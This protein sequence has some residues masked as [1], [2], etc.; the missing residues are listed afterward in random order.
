MRNPTK[1]LITLLCMLPLSS[2]L[3]AASPQVGVAMSAFDDNWLTILR[4]AIT[5][6]AKKEGATV[7]MEDGKNEVGTQLN[8]IQNFA[9]SSLQAI[10]VNPVDSTA[11]QSISDE[12]HEAEIPLVYVN[13]EP[14]N[15]NMLPE[16]Q[17]F[18]GSSEIEGGTLQGKEVCRLLNGKGNVL[19][20]QG[21]L[22]QQSAVLRT[23]AVEDVFKKAPC[24]GIKVVDKQIAKWTRTGGN[25]LMTN[26]LSTNLK[27]DAVVA[28][29]DEMALGAIQALHASN[30][31]MKTVV[32]AG[33][34]ATV[35][36]LNAM[37]A[38]DLDVTVFQDATAQGREAL[39]TAMK[40]VKG[41]KVPKRVLIPYQ[42]VTPAN[43]N[44][45]LK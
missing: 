44:Q 41:E 29:N 24:D 2:V 14:A 28:N 5:D 31:D 42:L 23:Q 36:A 15:I 18:V 3:H 21:D 4:S 10:I 17:A 16:N 6:E 35:D 43:M 34:D 12:A 38:G 37:K 25:N 8:Q 11:V 30:R 45:F 27:F 20:M 33:I 1:K 13:R 22:A 19:I 9:A 7:Q 39:V 32:V 40:L 26:W